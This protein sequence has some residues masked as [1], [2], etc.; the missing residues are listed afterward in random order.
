[1]YMMKGTRPISFRSQRHPGDFRDVNGAV[2]VS[3]S[4]GTAVSEGKSVM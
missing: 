2:G 1:M 3:S 4:T